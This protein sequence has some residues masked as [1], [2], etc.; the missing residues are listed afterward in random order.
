MDGHPCTADW[1]AVMLFKIPVL[2]LVASLAVLTRTALATGGPERP[3]SSELKEYREGREV[4]DGY[5]RVIFQ[6]HADDHFE[7][8]QRAYLFG[9]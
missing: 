6:R 4:P 5:K 8:H 2:L 9:G 7:I 1:F 3:V